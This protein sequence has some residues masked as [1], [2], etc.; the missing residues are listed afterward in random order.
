MNLHGKGACELSGI[1]GRLEHLEAFRLR[2]SSWSVVRY[3]VQVVR[4][5]AREA[6]RVGESV[7]PLGASEIRQPGIE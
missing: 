4:A 7:C 1:Y 2:G 3:V 5:Q 6:G